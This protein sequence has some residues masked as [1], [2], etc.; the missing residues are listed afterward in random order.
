MPLTADVAHRLERVTGM[1]ARMWNRLEADYRSD[2]QRLS[3]QRDLEEYGPWLKQL[4]VRE[5]VKRGVLPQTPNDKASRIEQMLSFFGVASVDAWADVYETLACAFRQTRAFEAKPGTV[6]AWLRLGET[7]AHDIHC[8]PFDRH[9]LIAALPTLRALTCEPPETFEPQMKAI[10]AA[11][12]V[13]VVFVA[14]IRGARAS[15][16][17][18]WLTPQKA[19]IQL[20]LRYRSDDHLWF[21]FFHELAHVILHGKTEVWIR[22]GETKD[23]PKE[24]QADHY[25]RDLL[26][27]PEFGPA[28]KGLRSL[29]AVRTF[30]AKI[31]ISPGVVVGRLQHDGTWPP[32][33][34]N[35]LKRR[36]VLIE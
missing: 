22:D 1:A 28:L 17:T 31:G 11:H 27:P 5:L 29:E 14:E 20:S 25:S 15:G 7:A 4:P 19:L 9:G 34:G 3:A 30:A 6:A 23:D 10:C 2:L 21:T 32:Q 26:I 16:V 12:G 13:A 24:A 36:F 18:R 35:G 8:E 33:N